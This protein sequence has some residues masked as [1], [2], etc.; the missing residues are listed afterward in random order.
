MAAR[1][2]WKGY[3]KLSLVSC[4][5]ALFPATTQTAKI[6]FHKLNGKTGHRL[7]M[8]MVDEESGEEVPPDRQVRGYEVDKD[9]HVVL[10]SEDL[11]AVAL[12]STHT[13]E[14][15]QFT[16]RDDIDPLYFDRVYLVAPDDEPSREAFNVIRFA[17][18]RKEVAALST[19]VLHDR[20]HMVL[21]EPRGPGLS[22]TLLHWPYEMQDERQVFADLKKSSKIDADLLDVADM[23]VERKMG[24]FDPS[25]FEDRY[26]EALKALADKVKGRKPK[27]REASRST[28]ARGL[29]EALRASLAEDKSGAN[30]HKAS[31]PRKAKPSAKP[32]T[33]RRAA[34]RATG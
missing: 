19:I 14:I 27:L 34:K 9:E 12:E 28:D 21:L 25:A 7:R 6:H 15:T 32:P 16:A 1:A 31:R 4:A 29:M 24:R 5:I 20:E 10:E 26:E 11:D 8:R 17:M 3:L 30:R 13:I 22:A 23:L 2:I 18:E 33:K